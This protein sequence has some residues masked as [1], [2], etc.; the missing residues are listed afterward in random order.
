MPFCPNPDCPFIKKIGRPAEYIDGIILCSDC[1]TPL[2]EEEIVAKPKEKRAFGNLEKRL[3]YTMSFLG[4]WRVLSHIAIPGIN[5]NSINNF[6][7]Q[8]SKDLIQ[9]N[10][11][12][13]ALGLIPYVTAY[14]LIEIL[15]L[16]VKPLKSWRDAGHEGRIKLRKTALG[17]TCIL[18]LVQG[19]GIAQNLVHTGDG[20]FINKIISLPFIIA[21]TLTAGT[22]VTIWIADQITNKGIGHGISVIIISSLAA[23]SNFFNVANTKS[24]SIY[25]SPFEYLFFGVL[26]AIPVIIIALTMET[27][28]KKF[29]I[30]YDDGTKAYIP[31]KI[32]TA[33]IIPIDWASYVVIIPMTVFSFVNNGFFSGVP[34]LLVLVHW[35]I[36][37]FM[38][39]LSFFSISYL[40]HIFINLS[41]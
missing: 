1:G 8:Q 18:A 20:F 33:G 24:L 40:Q 28:H 36:I 31:L 13:L 22:F 11:G 38:L 37:P 29:D 35:G 34:P 32:T 6:F 27:A 2:S 39:Y 23:G 15:A 7:P 21:L 26:I 30:N 3:L 25:H 12:I 4:L 19:F 16:F 41:R 9:P 10:V 17:A 5:L 14:V